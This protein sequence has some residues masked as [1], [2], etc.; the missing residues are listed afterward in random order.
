MSLILELYIRKIKPFC[1]PCLMP[2]ERT[3]EKERGKGR[4]EEKEN[5]NMNNQEN[6]GLEVKTK[7][8]E[9]ISGLHIRN[10]LMKFQSWPQ[11]EQV[12][13]G[14]RGMYMT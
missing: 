4:K 1:V 5:K 14:S 7:F 13:W 9:H 12:S 2:F 8:E 10:N 11:W 6:V 3:M